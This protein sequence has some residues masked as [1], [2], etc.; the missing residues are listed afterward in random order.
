M[1][2]PKASLS[3]LIIAGAFY[4]AGV[5]FPPSEAAQIAPERAILPP[6]VLAFGLGAIKDRYLTAVSMEAMVLDGLNAFKDKDPDID[7]VQTAEGR[8]ALRHK[9]EVAVEYKIPDTESADGWARLAVTAIADAGALSEPMK[10]IEPEGVYE[11]MFTAILARLDMFSRYAAGE[12]ARE[13]R[14]ARNG[15]GGVGLRYQVEDRALIVTE[16]TPDGPA[17]LA[18]MEA[19]DRILAI[20][21]KPVGED[22]EASRR[23]RGQ[24]GSVVALSVTRPGE[25]APRML[26]LRRATII[27]AT[28]TSEMEG[29]IATIA[30]SSFNQGTARAVEAALRDAKA[31][32]DF[33]GVILDLRGNPGGLLDQGV[34]VAGLFMDHGRIVSTRG[35]NPASVQI[36]N[37]AP[38]GVGDDVKLAVLVDGKSASAAEI[39]ASALQDSGRAV[40]VGTNSYGKGTVQ[41]IVRMPNDAEMTLT[42]SRYYSPSGYALHGLGVLPTLCTADTGADP[43]R[44]LAQME[45]DRNALKARLAGWRATTVEEEEVRRALRAGCPAARHDQ[46]QAQALDRDLARRLILAPALYDQAL[47]AST[48]ELPAKV[49][50]NTPRPDGTQPL[51]SH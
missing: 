37:A 31:R 28:V 14:A 41:T 30:I 19:G 39:V 48:P 6:Q 17:A 2:T 23:L 18:G 50:A 22:G 32:A 47:T 15:F 5:T 27:P 35:R 20:D 12:K 24:E 49:T 4:L 25:T 33:K 40:V 46:V 11:T 16:I 3:R 26:S 38:D 45:E 9:G 51:A 44:L 36:Y 7:F 10:T 34:A 1:V 42:W 13:R 43:D 29:G 8:I 21:G